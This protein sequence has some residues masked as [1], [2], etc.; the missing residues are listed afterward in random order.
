MTSGHGQH[1]EPQEQPPQ[2][3]PPGPP[4]YGQQPP[5]YGQPGPYGPP[6]GYGYAPMPAPGYRQ[7]PPEPKE[8]PLTVRAGLGAFMA[9]F[10]IGIGSAVVQAINPQDVPVAVDPQFERETGIDPDTLAEAAQQGAATAG[11]VL[12]LFFAAVYLLFIW[13]A[14]KGQNWARI[15]LWVLSGLSLLFTPLTFGVLSDL[16]PTTQMALLVFQLIAT[17]VGVVLL[18]LKPSNEWYSYEKWRRAMTP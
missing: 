14:W 13:F 8:R 18:A 12:S 5:P 15:V 1:D 11:V 10:L 2:W 4:P 16:L 9:S 7:P 3:Q 6:P 17:L